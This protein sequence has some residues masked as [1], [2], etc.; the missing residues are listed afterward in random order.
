[1][2]YYSKYTK[3]ELQM[4]WEEIDQ[5]LTSANQIAVR[6]CECLSGENC[7]VVIYKCDHRTEHERT[8]LF[9][10]C[11]RELHKWILENI[12]NG[13]SHENIRRTVK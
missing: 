12:N 11:F 8:C 2:E 13:N 4:M 3:E 9:E 7:P 6:L 5:P 1:M 10:P